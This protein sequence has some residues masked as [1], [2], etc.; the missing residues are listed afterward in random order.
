MKNNLNLEMCTACNG[1]CCKTYAGIYIPNDLKMEITE[2]TLKALLDSGKYA[3]DWWEGDTR[4][5]SLNQTFF[6]R[7][8]HEN[9]SAIKG[10]WGGCCVNFTNGIGCSLDPNNRPYQCRMLIPEYDFLTRKQNCYSAV[11][12]KAT[13]CDCA[14]AWYSYQDIMQK[15]VDDY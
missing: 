5:G 4:G 13:K 3:I 14:D 11:K 1:V 7:P 6:L 12:D 9:E 15:V 2:N 8:R 10:S